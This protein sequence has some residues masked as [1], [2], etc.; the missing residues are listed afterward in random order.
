M[1]KGGSK[2]LEHELVLPWEGNL[3]ELKESVGHRKTG[4]TGSPGSRLIRI[5]PGK[6]VG[7]CNV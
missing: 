4:L 1:K 6:V 5:V 7:S 2:K 3:D